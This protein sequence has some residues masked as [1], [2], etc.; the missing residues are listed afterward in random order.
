MRGDDDVIALEQG[1]CGERLLGKD[2]KRD[3]A[4][5]ARFEPALDRVEVDQR[6]AGAVDDPG[7]SRIFAIA[8]SPIIP[9]VSGVFGTCRVIRSARA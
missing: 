6:A 2:I 1:M 3:A 5:P 4:E 7:S 8:S 9:V